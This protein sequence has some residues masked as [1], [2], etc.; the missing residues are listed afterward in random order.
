MNT[1]INLAVVGVLAVA[2]LIVYAMACQ[3]GPVALSSGDS[4]SDGSSS[5][6]AY[7]VNMLALEPSE[8]SVWFKHAAST[9]PANAGLNYVTTKD[10]LS[11]GII[12]FEVDNTEECSAGAHVET[13][14]NTASVLP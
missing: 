7:A 6:K 2:Y 1:L 4:G 10:R 12:A 3:S 9:I 11:L 8:F 14:S 13:E 5:Y